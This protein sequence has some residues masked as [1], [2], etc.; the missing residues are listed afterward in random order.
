VTPTRGVTD[1]RLVL[2]GFGTVARRF[3]EIAAERETELAELHGLR[4][5]VSGASTAHHG[6]MTN[7][8]GLRAAEL[9]EMFERGRGEFP[10]PFIPAAALIAEAEATVAVESTPLELGGRV[11]IEH[12]EAA[13]AA[14]LDVITVN[15]GPL[16]WDYR[17]LQQLAVDNGRQFRFEGVVMDGCPV[18]NLV[19]FSLRGDKVTGFRGVLNSTTNYILDAITEGA[20]F[21][22]AL[23]EAQNAGFAEADPT[24]DIDGHDAAAKVAAMANVFFDAGITPDDVEHDTIR[25]ITADDVQRVMSYGRRLRVVCSAAI[26]DVGVE[27]RVEVETVRDDDPLYWVTGTTSAL[28]LQTEL[29][30]TIEILERQPT[31]NQT[32]YAIYNDLL[33][34]YGRR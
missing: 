7:P 31:V 9:L 28:I 21:D 23:T 24:F 29:A 20:S 4:L 26:T 5:L 25:T 33:T 17:R 1:V 22:E 13:F 10:D 8:V 27:A 2:L 34:I 19:E 6:V 14:G 16:A 12:V 18:F 3:C 30:G 32:A 15:K 11:A